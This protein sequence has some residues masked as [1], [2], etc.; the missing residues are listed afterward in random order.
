MA[1]LLPEAQ[2]NGDA[3]STQ[4]KDP[5]IEPAAQAQ[6]Q[7]MLPGGEPEQPEQVNEQLIE[8]IKQKILAI[9]P[10]IFKGVIQELADLVEDFKANLPVFEMLQYTQPDAYNNLLSIM[11]TLSTLAQ[12]M[13]QNGDL[14]TDQSVVSEAAEQEI[15]NNV[16]Q[17]GMDTGGGGGDDEGMKKKRTTY[18]IGTILNNGANGRPRIKTADGWKYVSAGMNA[19]VGRQKTNFD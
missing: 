19:G 17:Q 3:P 4:T 8:E 12:L 9:N 2:A 16:Q 13:L 6:P 15:V 1:D 18:P 5:G 10:D 7:P 14:P 11:G